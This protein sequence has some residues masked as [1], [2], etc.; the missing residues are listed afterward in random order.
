[1]SYP[2]AG[3]V[4]DCTPPGY[5]VQHPVI[6]HGLAVMM[7]SSAVYRFTAQVDP[8][9]HLYVA[10]LMGVD[11]SRTRVEE[12]GNILA[13][14][15][16]DLMRQTGMPNGL[17]ALCYS[18]DVIPEMVAGTL[19]QQRLTRLSPQHFNEADLAKKLLDSVSYR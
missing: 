18:A 11:V 10:S 9:R 6:P 5:N 16:I 17:Q 14:A 3:M 4:H 19:P 8:R 15:M 7:T 12:A 1:M 2:I 13:Q